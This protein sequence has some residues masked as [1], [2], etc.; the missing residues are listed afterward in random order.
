METVMKNNIIIFGFSGSGK[1]TVAS[2]LARRLK[3]RAVHPSS[4]LR[5]LLEG[6]KPNLDASTYGK[7]FWESPAGIQLF[8]DRLKTTEPMDF[9]CDQLLLALLNKG[10]I[11][12]DSWSLAW[13]TDQTIKIYLKASQKARSERVAK[14]SH[15]TLTKAIK[16][17]RLKDTETR[18]LYL[19]GKGFDL[20]RDTGV[21]DL[22]INTEKLNKAQVL[23]KILYFKKIF[24]PKGGH[25]K[26]NKNNDE[27]QELKSLKL[28][29]DEK[30]LLEHYQQF[31]PNF[32]RKEER[33]TFVHASLINVVSDVMDKINS[34]KA[35]AQASNPD[36]WL[37]AKAIAKEYK[38]AADA[39]ENAIL[40][41]EQDTHALEVENFLRYQNDER[42]VFFSACSDVIRDLRRPPIPLR[43]GFGGK[44]KRCWTLDEI[45]KYQ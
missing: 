37:N 22:I 32:V 42:Q 19:A 29:A 12:M 17:V 13:Q 7:G 9:Y 23:S 21:F 6:R 39:V 15:I 24:H 18:K 5:E 35:A 36:V 16:Y 27:W 30:C 3:W 10:N 4:I 2:E 38:V 33:K 43:R 8:T 41:Y 25:V 20:R 1:S 40:K 28:T 45:E 14:R 31:N 44:T 11:V 26:R 34:A